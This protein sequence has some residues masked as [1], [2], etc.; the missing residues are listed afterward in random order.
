M[1][2]SIPTFLVK[3]LV[4][5]AAIKKNNK[6]QCELYAKLCSETPQE[7]CCTGST[8][9]MTFKCQYCTCGT[10]EILRAVYLQ[11]R[12]WKITKRKM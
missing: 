11:Q 9:L 1:N 4:F 6:P 10:R 7:S 5:V 8:L 12:Q 2:S 3:Y